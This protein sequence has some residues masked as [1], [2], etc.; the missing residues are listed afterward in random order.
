MRDLKDI[1][2]L[3]K[4]QSQNQ[5]F[6]FEGSFW[7]DVD[8]MLDANQGISGGLTNDEAVH[9]AETT[10]A[11]G[12]SGQSFEYKESY[13]SEMSAALDRAERR[14]KFILWSKLV[15]AAAVLGV[16]SL[17]A[18]IFIQDGTELTDE[19]HL[20][21]QNSSFEIQELSSG[22]INSE[23]ANHSNTIS[24]NAMAA[25]NFEKGSVI[26]KN[27]NVQS[28]V[29]DESDHLS[30]NR[31]APSDKLNDESLISDNKNNVIAKNDA[32]NDNRDVKKNDVDQLT[33]SKELIP[34]LGSH[35]V[36]LSSELSLI[37]K[38]NNAR[39]FKSST[40]SIHVGALLANAPESNLEGNSRVG[41][42]FKGGLSY[43]FIKNR[44]GLETGLN[45]IYRN[46][47]NQRFN[48][49]SNRYGMSLYREINQTMYKSMMS[50]EIPLMATVQLNRHRIGLGF[51]GVY[52]IAV[53]STLKKSNNV[54]D[55]EEIVRNNYANSDGMNKF[56]ARVQINYEFKINQ[57]FDVGLTAQ[58]G[59][60]NQVNTDVIPASE[61]YNELNASIYIKYNIFKF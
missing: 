32:Q 14:K 15:G 31:Q 50:L 39:N 22:R 38:L 23:K 16:I 51:S 42:G 18:Y 7:D 47:L 29:K 10:L 4:D 13:W 8:S 20:T 11:S 28:N 49:N 36:D 33:L 34:V 35:T 6:T 58:Y 24:E 3:M 41:Y 60:L 37:P 59:L 40:F 17:S 12:T 44:W 57:H 56:D 5:S 53:N 2:Q 26:L 54:S 30:N 25:A 1:E 27:G 61:G 48:Q 46:G 43:Q 9:A 45:F 55:S 21:N 52:N 19:V